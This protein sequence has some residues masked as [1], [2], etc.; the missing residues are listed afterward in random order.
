[1]AKSLIRHDETLNTLGGGKRLLE[2]F[3]RA[4]EYLDIQTVGVPA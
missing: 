1:M 4:V 3:R 2:A